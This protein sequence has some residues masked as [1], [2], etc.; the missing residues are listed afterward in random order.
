MRLLCIVLLALNLMCISAHSQS[1]SESSQGVVLM[2]LFTSQGCSSCPP[3]DELLGEY[4][5]GKNNQIIPL[6]FHVDYWNRLGWTDPFSNAA[7]SAR[8]QWYGQFLPGQSIYT[9]QLVVNG[10]RETVGNNRMAVKKLVEQSLDMKSEESLILDRYETSGQLFTF[11]YKTH[12]KAGNS[13]LQIVLVQKKIVTQIKAGENKGVTLTN[14]NIVR[15]FETVEC[16]N[17]GEGKINLPDKFSASDY[18]VVLFLQ[19]KKD[20]L[21]TAAIWQNL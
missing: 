17:D 9:P 15:S 21:V 4:A 5:T 2:E 14:H 3:A 13:L 8:Q 19:R 6:A 10:Q 1:K 7:F 12:S 18:A 11:H 20:H 16:R